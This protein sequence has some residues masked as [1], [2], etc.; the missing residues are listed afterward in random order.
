MSSGEP[1]PFHDLS[2]PP[3]SGKAVSGS[4][5]LSR[6][7]AVTRDSR[8]VKRRVEDEDDDEDEDD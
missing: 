4:R 2:Y 6:A 5:G 3:P 1:V 7:Q 8:A